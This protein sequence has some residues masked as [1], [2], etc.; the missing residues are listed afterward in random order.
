MSWVYMQ[1]HKYQHVFFFAWFTVGLPAN[2][3]FFIQEQFESS[4]LSFHQCLLP[5][6][7]RYIF[8]N[9]FHS[10][11][12]H[13]I[14]YKISPRYETNFY[15]LCLVPTQLL[16]FFFSSLWRSS[17]RWHTTFRPWSNLSKTGR[18][19]VRG[20][21]SPLSW[22]TVRA[23]CCLQSTRYIYLLHV[24]WRSSPLRQL[25]IQTS[26]QICSVSEVQMDFVLFK[27]SLHLCTHKILCL[28]C[29]CYFSSSESSCV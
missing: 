6:I 21:W 25:H 27:F 23:C 2:M 12:L 3:L 22:L 8:K 15:V 26:G 5:R 18:L 24:S 13:M 10:L 16:S 7:H 11:M 28:I 20:G 4:W 1:S 14:S 29:V 19:C 9:M 17:S